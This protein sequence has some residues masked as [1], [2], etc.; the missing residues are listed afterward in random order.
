[1]PGKLVV[2]VDGKPKTEYLLDPGEKLIIG[3]H[4]DC[5]VRVRDL[6]VSARHAAL[7]TVI[8]ES[9]IEDLGST[10]GTYVNGKAISR[11]MLND[12]D[13]ISIGRQMLVYR[14]PAEAPKPSS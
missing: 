3:R 10:N 13:I 5:D 1:M 14:G 4:R 8:E 11:C 6:A 7:I 9:V 12:G 2:T